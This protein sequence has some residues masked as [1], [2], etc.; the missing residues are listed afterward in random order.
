VVIRDRKNERRRS[1]DIVVFPTDATFFVVV[2]GK[3]EIISLLCFIYRERETPP[4]IR[5]RRAREREKRVLLL[6]LSSREKG[7]ESESDARSTLSLSLS[8][9]VCVCS[10]FLKKTLVDLFFSIDFISLARLLRAS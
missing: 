10:K 4:R 9:S 6:L 1:A 7:R 3:I 5:A 2:A 8:L